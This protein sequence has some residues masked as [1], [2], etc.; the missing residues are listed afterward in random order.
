MKRKK[1]FS[2]VAVALA[3]LMQ[4]GTLAPLRVSAAGVFDGQPF[5]TGITLKDANGNTLNGNSGIKVDKDSAVSVRFDFKVPD[6]VTIPA[7][8]TYGFTLPAEISPASVTPGSL[9]M[10]D[11]HG[12]QAEI[13]TYTV[14]SSGKGTITFENTVNH[15]AGI[16]G[17]FQINCQFAGDGIGNTTPV[18]LS[19]HVDGQSDPT[20][21]DVYFNQPAATLQKDDG[22]YHP[23]TNTVTWTVTV[24]GNR[25]TVDNGKFVDTLP[26]GLTYKT[27]TF[28]VK[29]G[30]TVVYQD[31]GSTNTGT[32]ASDTANNRLEYDFASSFSD[33][34]TVQYD[35]DVNPDFFGKTLTNTAALNHDSI[36]VSDTGT[37]TASPTYI[38]K[39]AG[40]VS[41]GDT[42]IT[43]TITFNQSG[44]TLHNVGITDPITG[45][46]TLDTGAGVY[47]DGSTPVSSD[48]AASPAQ[49][50]SY[51]NNQL[52]F[53]ADSVSGQHTLT[54]TTD[55]P[56]GYWQQNEGGVS[57]SAT[58]TAGDNT[59]LSGGVT[60]GTGVV[61]GSGNSTLSKTGAGYN[62]ATHTI[63]WN[64]LVNGDGNA[65]KSPTLTDMIP[66]EAGN[67]Q[68]YVPGTFTVRDSSGATVFADGSGTANAGTFSS[69]GGQLIYSFGKDIGSKYTVTFQT[70][71]DAAADY[72]GNSSKNYANGVTLKTSDNFVTTTGGQ[73]PVGSDVLKKSADYNYQTRDLSW[74]LT[75]NKN[76]MPMT[77]VTLSDTLGGKDANGNSTNLENFTLDTD[78]LY[79]GATR[80]TPGASADALAQNQ[81]YYDAGTRLLTVYLGDIG[82]AAKTVT[83]A[84]HLNDPEQYFA[85]NGDKS[86][87]NTANLTD[88]YHIPASATGS[89]TIGN[90]LV[91]K[92]GDY[93]K[94][95]DH[96]D[97]IV[98]INQNAI[99]ISDL[100]LTDQL[101]EGLVLDTSSVRLYRQQVDTTGALSPDGAT[102]AGIDSAAAAGVSA[103][104]LTGDNIQYDAVTRNFTFTVPHDGGSGTAGD[105]YVVS[106]PYVLIFRTYVDAA[107]SQTSFRN[108]ISFDGSGQTQSTNA[109]QVDVWYGSGSSGATGTTGSLTV[110]KVD[111]ASRAALANAEFGLYDRYGNRIQ[112][113]KTDGSGNLTFDYIKYTEPYSLQETAA[114]SGNYLLNDTVHHFELKKDDPAGLYELNTDTGEYS[115]VSATPAYTYEDTLKIGAVTFKKADQ[116]GKPLAGVTFT[117]CDTD[118]N[119]VSIP[120]A[121]TVRQ[122]GDDGTVTFTG[123]PYGHYTVRESAP[124]DYTSPGL[125]DANLNYQSAAAGTLDL[126][127][128]TNTIK[129]A[130]ITVTK[131][132]EG[133][134]K[135]AGVTFALTYD[136]AGNEPLLIGGKAV[137]AATG[138]DGTAS[139]TGIPYGDY[140]LIETSAPADYQLAAPA[141]VS[142][143]DSNA[144]LKNGV[145]G[146]SVTDSLKR[147]SIRFVKL[148]DDGSAL[149]GATFVL[150]DAAGNPVGA[151]QTSGSDG[152]V[153][154]TDV[155]YGDGYSIA[156][157][158]APNDFNL[159]P[160]PI[161]GISLHSSE[162]VLRSVTDTRKTGSITL[163]KV[164]EGGSPLPGA[165]FAL[166]DAAG[167]P[168][169]A[170]QVSD[171]DGKITFTGVPLKDGYTVREISAPKDYALHD[172]IPV[173]LHTASYDCG[174]IVDLLLRGEIRVVKSDPSGKTLAGA[175][176][177][178][179]DGD[180]RYLAEAVSG[181]DGTA[182]FSNLL[183]GNYSVQEVKAP[184]G[185]GIDNSMHAVTLGQQSPSPVVRVVDAKKPDTTGIGDNQI[186]T[187]WANGQ[188]PNPNTGRGGSA[189]GASALALLAGGGAFLC[190]DTLRRKHRGRRA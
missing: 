63:T 187:G 85:V 41:R 165:T 174:K 159:L 120:G 31:G 67:A 178:L 4:L 24:N 84:M 172:A 164:D 87:S 9:T 130:G 176:F 181:S 109:G 101:P 144:Q 43:W 7:G 95:N 69:A 111:S 163:T 11:S 64:I 171:A 59:Y 141:A 66:T 44:G 139:F 102:A 48:K 47:L 51:E 33:V 53:H 14:D 1:L 113:G 17:Y 82:S 136:Q 98:R 137:T 158:Q 133:G 93:A 42:K 116:D 175:T 73:Q 169:G 156:E 23:D 70:T 45:N 183:Y 190:A 76:Q 180:G 26:V 18:P 138:T 127:T 50:Y 54:Y 110:T 117:L 80:L 13:A 182:V 132:A 119:P 71:V 77:G 10:T 32:F 100:S 184:A 81:Y 107:H 121:T 29:D 38:A 30:G 167:N 186:P 58:I 61:P 126:G 91:T 79:V 96:I 179:Y 134:G 89:L 122:S 114:P 149:A 125:I 145:L 6:T 173:G 170:P 143:H 3:L 105:P 34:Y 152:G 60:A 151:P 62:A 8:T 65:L 74:T 124:A 142:L 161:T 75:V 20:T 83:F 22:V 146:V 90:K 99:K 57:N 55:L 97:W 94:Y 166:Y 36:S 40:A 19:F 88:D 153:T 155:P 157:T 150:R 123:I 135:L 118:G 140:Y 104:A 189:A 129:T 49:Y 56:A 72:A 108:S 160:E 177:A 106:N 154:F 78:T 35:T 28:T 103:A 68:T 162:V 147:G 15:Y 52:T 185:Y 21:I 86:V 37:V 12:Q 2:F 92:T 25:T 46:M 16:T 188:T 112:T 148:G 168:V 115:F 131:S 39:T 27:G 128:V 5:I